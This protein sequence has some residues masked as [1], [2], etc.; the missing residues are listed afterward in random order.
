MEQALAKG[1]GTRLR[2]A[3]GELRASTKGLAQQLG[4]MAVEDCS[5]ASVSRYE[6]EL[7][8]PGLDYVAAVCQLAGYRVEWIISNDGPRYRSEAPADGVPPE[9]WRE[10]KASI[11]AIEERHFGGDAKARPQPQDA[12]LERAAVEGALA[13]YER[14]RQAAESRGLRTRTGESPGTAVAR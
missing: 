10:L 6:N 11:R 1:W 2:E 13:E 8:M 4:R 3:R 7:R 5:D 12:A 9:P 14:I